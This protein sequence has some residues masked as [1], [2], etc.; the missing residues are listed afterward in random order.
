[1]HPDRASVLVTSGPNAV[2][3]N[4]M[5][6]GL[7][8]LLLANGVRRGSWAGLLPVVVFVA[9]VDRLQI[10]PEEQALRAKFGAQYDDYCAAVPRWLDRRSLAGPSRRA[11]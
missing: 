9:A 5:Y 7:T 1:V 3:R 2:T 4:P 6:V 10:A 8:G 11:A